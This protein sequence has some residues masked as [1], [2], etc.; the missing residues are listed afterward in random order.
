MLS[1]LNLQKLTKT[2]KVD[3]VVK[4]E[5]KVE[6][7]IYYL[8]S[9]FHGHQLNVNPATPSTIAEDDQGVTSAIAVGTE[10]ESKGATIKTL[11][12]E[13]LEKKLTLTF[14]DAFAYVCRDG[15]G[16]FHIPNGEAFHLL[17]ACADNFNSHDRAGIL[18]MHMHASYKTAVPPNVLTRAVDFI[19]SHLTL[20]RDDHP[21]RKAVASL[22]SDSTI[23]ARHRTPQL[24]LLI[25]VIILVV[26]TINTF[27]YTPC[28]YG[29]N[30]AQ[31]DAESGKAFEAHFFRGFPDFYF[32]FN[33]SN[34][35]QI[36]V[37]RSMMRTLE[38]L[39]L[40]SLKKI[41]TDQRGGI[42]NEMAMFLHVVELYKSHNAN[43]PW[44]E[45]ELHKVPESYYEKFIGKKA[46][47]PQQA[48]RRERETNPNP[49]GG[50]IEK[51][52]PSHFNTDA[53]KKEYKEWSRTHK[54]G[55]DQR[56]FDRLV[57]AKVFP[58]K[59]GGKFDWVKMNNMVAERKKNQKEKK[60]EKEKEEE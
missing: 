29:T 20:I 21:L 58:S 43:T 34:M 28:S 47:A 3:T 23:S 6:R 32:C 16:F 4:T 40:E 26:Y 52:K 35:E 27:S 10:D 5:E 22:K 19:N 53:Q 41:S 8:F 7:N 12:K 45:A 39:N 13:S 49:Q 33:F 54:V 56:F 11:N 57:R 15:N 59:N 9:V 31:R 55:T 60:E 46:E 42:I 17:E 51:K 24:R 37:Q 14:M 50:L 36:Q 25:K 48:T 44:Y 1:T 18:K 30:T 38:A 2:P